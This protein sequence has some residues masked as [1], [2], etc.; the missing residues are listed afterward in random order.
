LFTL[1]KL[2]TGFVSSLEGA[3]DYVGSG[4]AKLIGDDAWAEDIIKNDWFGDWYSH[5]EEWFNPAGGWKVAGDVAGGIGTS[6]PAIVSTAVVGYVTK[7][8][9]LPSFFASFA[10]AALGAAGRSTKAAYEQTGELGGKEFGYGALSGLTE[11]TVEAI[12]NKIGIGSGVITKQFTRS[13]GREVGESAV[14]QGLFKT[15]GYGFAGEAMEEMVAEYLDPYWKR[16]TYDADAENASAEQILYSGLVGG[17]SGAVMGGG[18]YGI[19]ATNSFIKGN[20]LSTNGGI[21]EVLYTSENISKYVEEN[22][23]EDGVFKADQC[24]RRSFRYP[25]L[26]QSLKT[27]EP[28]SAVM[29]TDA[30]GIRRAYETK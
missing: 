12:S 17:L 15:V 24:F 9:A 19:N 16:A 20:K 1:E 18:G 4:F 5:P 27:G 14:K 11:G 25:E 26:Q 21:D 8:A 3:V 7:G 23:I 10:P 13:L 29:T 28:V 30:A 22:G 2:A 6:I